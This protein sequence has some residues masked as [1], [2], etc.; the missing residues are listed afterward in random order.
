MLN[1][2]VV[3]YQYASE[4]RALSFDHPGFLWYGG[5]SKAATSMARLSQ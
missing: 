5:I 4:V 1:S 3:A 2:G